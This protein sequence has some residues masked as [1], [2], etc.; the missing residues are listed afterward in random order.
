MDLTL[1][2]EQRQIA[3]A[4]DDLLASECGAAA[5]RHAAF[6]L[7]G[8]DGALW[9]KLAD[10]GACGIHIPEAYGG[11]GVGITSALTGTGGPV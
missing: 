8:F 2:E 4:V 1:T 7:G 6:E 5:M 3:A 10:L 9:R 11:L